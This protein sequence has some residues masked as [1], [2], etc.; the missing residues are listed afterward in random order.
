[1]ILAKYSFNSKKILTPKLKFE[2]DIK[3]PCFSNTTRI[4]KLKTISGVVDALD[5][6]T[7][8]EAINKIVSETP[9]AGTT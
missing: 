3:P 5:D 6:E 1:M 7:K 9:A 8:R 2:L 4:K